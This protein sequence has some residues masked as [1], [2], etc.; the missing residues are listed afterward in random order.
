MKM[1]GVAIYRALLNEMRL[2]NPNGKLNKDSQL[3]QYVTAQFKKYQTTDEVLC[4]AKEEMKYIGETY[5]CYISSVRKHTEIIKHYGGKGER[6][7]RE[8]A[9]IVGFKLPHDPK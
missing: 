3:F 2:N 5:L 9:G 6:S 4:K 7:V 8:T 1:S